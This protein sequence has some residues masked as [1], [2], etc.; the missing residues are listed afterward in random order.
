MLKHG[1]SYSIAR[2][3]EIVSTQTKV[4]VPQSLL[5][6]PITD[7]EYSERVK[8][9]VQSKKEEDIDKIRTRQPIF[10]RKDLLG[11][12][13][14]FPK[15]QNDIIACKERL[16]GFKNAAVVCRTPVEMNCEPNRNYGIEGGPTTGLI[17]IRST[18][19]KLGVNND[20]YKMPACKTSKVSN[21]A[22]SNQ[23]HGDSQI[24]KKIHSDCLLALKQD[25]HG[26]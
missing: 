12:A 16:E 4:F 5:H 1:I 15:P 19:R 13:P 20:E 6:N 23:V 11:R 21:S 17:D 22:I 24:M 25:V 9:Y 10:V 7:P 14:Q 26:N 18:K 8:T 2:L 3:E